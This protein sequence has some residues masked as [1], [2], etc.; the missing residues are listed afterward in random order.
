LDF[1]GTD[2]GVGVPRGPFSV[3]TDAVS[4]AVIMVNSPW[5][6]YTD[7]MEIRVAAGPTGPFGAP[8][9]VPLPDCD[10]TLAG[11]PR[12]CYAANVQPFLTE[13]GVLGVGWYDQMVEPDSPRG[14]F[15]ASQIPLSVSTAD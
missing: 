2:D 6:S 10:D 5:P 4:G 13:K 14:S 15:V 1:I 7:S 12:R 3:V 11:Q 9:T 8:R